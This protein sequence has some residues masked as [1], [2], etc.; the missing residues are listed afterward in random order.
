MRVVNPVWLGLND[1]KVP[2]AY[3]WSDGSVVKYRNWEVNQ[4]SIG[5]SGL[6]SYC[7]VIDP[8]TVNGT[9]SSTSCYRLRGYV[10]KI[11]LGGKQ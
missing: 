11:K 10:C 6:F 2:G 7:T 3:T 1:L 8:R 5:T 9:W 4:P